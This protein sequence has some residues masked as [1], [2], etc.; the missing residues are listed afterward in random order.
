MQ[1]S[2]LVIFAR[3]PVYGK[4][5]KRLATKLGNAKALEIHHRLVEHTLAV[6]KNSGVLYKVYL[7]EESNAEQTF[8][9]ELQSGDDLGERMNNAL[10][11]ELEE[12]TKVC[13]IGSDCLA[14]TDI[15]ITNA[16]NQLGEADVVIG[17]AVD[18]G[19]YLI[20]MT[21][22]QP[23]LFPNISWGS[24]TVLENTLQKCADSNLVVHQLKLLNDI[25][26]PEDVPDDWL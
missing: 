12:Y 8:S 6:V 15:D 25:D 1:K 13:L 23:Q 2:L 5:K 11:A 21:K 4:V 17:P 20:G 16:F 22:P 19:Y 18:G 26:R 24:S 10:L 3:T 7:S 9:Y 14:L